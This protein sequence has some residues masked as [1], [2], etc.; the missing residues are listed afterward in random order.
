MT[1]EIKITSLNV[2]GLNN[3]I[4]RKIILLKMKR[5]GGDVMFLQETHLSKEEHKKLEILILFSLRKESR[6]DTD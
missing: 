3:P 5:E 1:Q 2:N 4:K 6:G